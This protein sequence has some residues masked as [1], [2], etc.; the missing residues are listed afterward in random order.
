VNTYQTDFQRWIEEQAAFLKGSQFE[1]LD[2]SHLVEELESMGARDRRELINRLAVLIAH[3]LKWQYQPER[4]SM[5][6]RLTI[7]EQRRQLALILEDSPSLRVRLPEFLSRAYANGM[8][9]AVD[10]TGL[11]TFPFPAEC[12]WALS[13]L[14]DETFW[15]NTVPPA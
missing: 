7:N 12:P 4:R 6:W 5:S 8:R 10:E 3:L 2:I 9:A 15:P 1:R 13:Q 11:A 14:F